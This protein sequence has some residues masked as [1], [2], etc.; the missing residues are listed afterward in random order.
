MDPSI[1]SKDLGPPPPPPILSRGL[2]VAVFAHILL[3]VALAFGVQWKREADPSA[4][5][6]LPPVTATAAPTAPSTSTMGAGPAATPPAPEAAP[7]PRAPAAAPPALAETPPRTATPAATP[8]RSA[9]PSQPPAQIVARNT[10]PETPRTAPAERVSPSF[11]CAK[12]R[13][14]TERLIC[15]DPELS[16]LDRDLGRLYARARE[17]SPNP[18]AFR[19]D[20]DAQWALRERTCRDRECLVRWYAQR[21]EQL[22]ASLAQNEARARR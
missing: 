15:A 19:R 18:A 16:R 20:S 7:A 1:E 5:I 14:I 4:S 11:D 22:N 21:R 9:A 12:A 10:T 6:P 8:P 13:S 3:G 2:P 17:A